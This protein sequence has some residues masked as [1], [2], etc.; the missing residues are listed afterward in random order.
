MAHEISTEPSGNRVRI[1]V[2]GTLL[3]DTDNAV[4]LH[5]AGLP[6]RRYLPRA[7]VRMELLERTQ[8]STH[9]PFKGDAEYFSARIGEQLH[10]DLAWSYPTPLE[11]RGDIAELIA[12]DDDRVDTVESD[13]PA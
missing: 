12:F 5:E 2:D 6:V 10:T 4:L 8:T 11:H 1:E 9:C 7:D 13:L 3:A